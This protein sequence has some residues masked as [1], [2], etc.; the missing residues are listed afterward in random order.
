M[1]SNGTRWYA[2]IAYFTT[3]L[4]VSYVTK[5]YQN[6]PYAFL[7]YFF[8]VFHDSKPSPAQSKNRKKANRE[9]D[10]SGT[11]K[12]LDKLDFSGSSDQQREQKQREEEEEFES[13]VSSVFIGSLKSIHQNEVSELCVRFL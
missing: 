10:Q 1:I 11:Q 3:K 6:E 13:M 2:L 12:D 5:C 9:W 8:F 7:N 4:S